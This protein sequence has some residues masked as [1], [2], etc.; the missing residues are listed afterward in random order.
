MFETL[1][2]YSGFLA[3]LIPTLFDIIPFVYLKHKNKRMSIFSDLVR[4]RK[5]RW[6]FRISMF[7][8]G[9]SQVLFAL[10]IIEYTGIY[11][12]SILYLIGCFGTFGIS[13][14]NLRKYRQ[15]HDYSSYFFF[16]GVLGSYFFSAFYF[17]D[18]N[19]SMFAI[20]QLIFLTELAY[21]LYFI[22][23]RKYLKV[24]FVHSML[25][26]I[27]IIAAYFFII[28]PNLNN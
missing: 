22:P 3:I 14:F 6:L 9:V 17:F 8:T 7:L 24:E 15:F 20:S 2:L 4:L 10:L 18:K 23:R 19:F 11:I 26:S 16:L 28:I 1:K 25:G 21:V 12:G 5:T 13:I 27:W